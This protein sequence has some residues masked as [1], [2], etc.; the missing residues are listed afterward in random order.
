MHRR[1]L[2]FVIIC[3]LFVSFLNWGCNKLDT[4]DIG[5]DLLPAVDNV[6]T[7]AD[8][9][10]I[11]TT[12]GVYNPDTTVVTRTADQAFGQMNDP[13]F[14]QTT[15]TTYFQFKPTFYP[16]FLGNA[17]D[18]LYN[19]NPAF[20][21]GLD[22][23]ILCL[24]YTGNY[25]DSTIPLDVRVREVTDVNFRDKVNDPNNVNTSFHLGSVVGSASIDVR[26]LADTVRYV[27]NV[28]FSVNT[29]R[30]KL[31]T[32]Y[33]TQ[34][35]FRDTLLANFGNDAFYSDSLFRQ[36][37]NGLAVEVTGG[38]GN[39]L[40][41]VNL[42]D[43]ASRLEVHY[44]KR[45]AGTGVLDTTFT[46]LVLNADYFGSTINRSSNTGDYITRNRPAL[47]SGDQEIYLQTNPGTYAN[48]KI[49]ALTGLS[50]RIVHRA[51]L[52]ITQIPDPS[53]T[54]FPSPAYL[55]LDLKDSG[56][57]A[58][59]K[60]IYFDL[61]TSVL[62]D[63]DNQNPLSVNF[64]PISSGVDYL[65]YGGYR[66]DGTDKFGNVTNIYNFNITKY[67]QDIATNHRTNY[68]LR[69]SSP[70]TF[71]YPQYSPT[72]ISYPNSV[73]NGRVKVGGGNN[74]NYKMILRIIYSNL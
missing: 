53:R 15:A 57:V 73:A 32:A 26:R 51:E 71:F 56:T 30:I 55:Y 14:G 50:N 16:F 46:S 3:F 20:M 45:T 67:V 40:I 63:P 36:F 9:L 38:S 18:T 2:P 1:I 21:V 11:T 37:Y 65:Y 39:Q 43:P 31:S 4:T 54:T 13:L 49:P 27:D 72:A 42:A 47:P 24:K 66:K 68:D 48:L 59:W 41:Y 28:D 64:F 62:Y 34:L 25:G 58:K 10:A 19:A 5:S 35:F 17:G 8:T 22:S 52:I 12:Q 61:N 60:P 7:F 70:F 74:P 29:I 44:R 33:A 69:L 23:V 6:H